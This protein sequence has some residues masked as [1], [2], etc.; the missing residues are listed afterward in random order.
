MRYILIFSALLTQVACMTVSNAGDSHNDSKE[1][2][3]N[4]D[5]TCLYE[6][7]YTCANEGDATFIQQSINKQ[8][9]Q[10]QHLEY[11]SAAYEAF[12]SIQE[13][14][15]S[16]KEL[17]HYEVGFVTK[18]NEIIVYFSPFKI[19]YIE[20]NKPLGISRVTYGKPVKIWLNKENK[21]MVKYLFL[22]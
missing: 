16:Q 22:K 10:A 21:E 4:L 14:T 2:I 15:A 7:G 19:P 12:L 18:S 6:D 5:K 13:L 1:Y 3:E 11:W 20:N 17:H 9:I 8:L